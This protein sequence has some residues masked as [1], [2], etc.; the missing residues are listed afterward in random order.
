MEGVPFSRLPAGELAEHLMERFPFL[1]V[2]LRQVRRAL[3]RLVELGLVVREQFWQ[4]ERW[5]SDYFY[6]LPSYSVPAPS[7][8]AAVEVPEVAPSAPVEATSPLAPTARRSEALT[9]PSVGREPP[10]VA[11][12][13]T[14]HSP[15]SA[16]EAPATADKT[17]PRSQVGVRPASHCLPVGSPTV[18]RVGSVWDRIRSLASQFDSSLVVP[19]SPQGVVVG[20]RV[21]RVSDGACRP[22]R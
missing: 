14:P 18:G 9:A 7:V 22:I 11:A 19:V 4:S 3:R 13:P 1:S 12:A 8:D 21:F 2:T 16:S 10:V 15:W 5:R 17:A 6:T 20:G